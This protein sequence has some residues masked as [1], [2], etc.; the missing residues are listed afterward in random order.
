[1]E[2]TGNKRS[3]YD[4]VLSVLKGKKPDRLPFIGRLELWHKGLTWTGTLP[5]RFR[6]MTLTEIHRDVGMGQQK[7]CS[8]H[9][10]RLRGVEMVTTFEDKV[11]RH[12]T[13]PVIERFPD[14]VEVVPE[15]KIGVTT[16]ELITPVGKLTVE[17]TML[18]EMMASGAR[19]YMSQHPIKEEADVR[20]VQ[21]ILERAELVP[22]F[23]ELRQWKADL[24]DVGFV[25]PS[26]D[27][28]PFQHLLID[29]FNTTSLFYTLH[30]SPQT[31]ARLLEVLD[32]ITTESLHNV[33]QL[34][35]PY[36]EF[37][38]NLDGMMT[39][40]KLFTEYCLPSYQRYT[41]ILHGQGKK[42]G[43]HT[44]GHLSPLLE[45]MPETGLDVCESFS[46]FPL[47]PCPFDDA[48]KAWRK[49]PM[50]WGGIPSPLLE[51]GTSEGEFR[52]T[53]GRILATVGSEPIILCVA[54]MV[55]PNNS[56]ERVRAIAELVE[57]HV[58]E[59]V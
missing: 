41:E 35:F 21:Y 9:K 50:I 2:P 25:V 33:A 20:V 34:D 30:D 4:R 5:E 47:T 52:E 39:N 23:D 37:V 8:A 7:L 6:G 31:I 1:M 38:D 10:L 55:L 16:T 58:L 12:E 51:K 22:Q 28:I 3:I 59:P 18:E 45:L 27:R 57:D 32:R 56:I 42:V 24:G 43:S 26:L 13:D 19:A 40:P 14:I 46:P 17:H 15:K 36:V 54:D 48:W 11:I 49:G 53:I 29:F 44:D